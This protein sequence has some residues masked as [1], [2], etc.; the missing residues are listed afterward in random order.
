MPFTRLE[1]LRQPNPQ[2]MGQQG[3]PEGTSPAVLAGA[4]LIDAHLLLRVSRRGMGQWPGA[5]SGNLGNIFRGQSH[6][7]QARCPALCAAGRRFTPAWP[8][9]LR[10]R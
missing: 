8:D 2:L 5:R 6:L 9:W 7:C 3:G 1:S 10:W 4:E